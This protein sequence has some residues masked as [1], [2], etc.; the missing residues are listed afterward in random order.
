MIRIKTASEHMKV[1]IPIDL[2]ANRESLYAAVDWSS[3]NLT[4]TESK[5]EHTPF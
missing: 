1:P 3:Q 5:G 4:D 2:M